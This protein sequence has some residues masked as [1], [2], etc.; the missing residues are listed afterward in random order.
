M[1][2]V[3][4]REFRA[5]AKRRSTFTLRWL[6]ALTAFVLMLWLFWLFDAYKHAAAIP[7]VFTAMSHVA[8][9]YCLLVSAARAA[10][11]ISAER[12]DGTLGLLFLTD[13]RTLEV[14]AGKLVTH[15]GVGAYGLLAIFP[16]LAVPM[17]LGG[18]TFNQFAWTILSLLNAMWFG[19][20]LG[21][22]ISVINSRQHMAIGLSLALALLCAPG[23]TALAELL[24]HFKFPPWAVDL[25]SMLS[26][27]YLVGTPIW[28]MTVKPWE[29]LASVGMV[30]AMGWVLLF[31]ALLEL[32][33][34]WRDSA[35]IHALF[36]V[37]KSRT[38]ATG[39]GRSAR[40]AAWRTRMLDLHP[41]FWL[42]GRSR[43]GSK[44]FLA[45]AVL[46]I[47]LNLGVVTKFAA[48]QFKAGPAFGSLIG[49]TMTWFGL[50]VLL[51]L[52]TAYQAGLAASHRVAED[53]QTGAL[54]LILSTPLGLRSFSRGL[55]MA[56]A[57][58]LFAPAVFATLVHLFFV[59][60]IAQLFFTEFS[61]RAGPFS[62]TSFPQYLFDCLVVP[63]AAHPVNQWLP[64]FVGRIM[65]MAWF[66]LAANWVAIGWVGRWLGLRMK[67]TG[68]A[69][70]AA[71][72]LALVP[73]WIG[74]G[75]TCYF[76]DTAGVFKGPEENTLPLG[77]WLA[78]C[79][80]FGHALMLSLWGRHRWWRYFSLVVSE[81]EAFKERGIH[82]PTL[83]RWMGYAVVTM[84]LLASANYVLQAIYTSRAKS[85]WE[86]VRQRIEG[87]GPRQTYA[88]MAPP[89][90]GDHLNF[91]Q[92]PAYSRWLES[93]GGDLTARIDES[94]AYLQASPI[95]A[96][97]SKHQKADL[98]GILGTWGSSGNKETGR[99]SAALELEEKMA[100]AG[101]LLDQINLDSKTRTHYRSLGTQNHAA[102][103]SKD[104]VAMLR[105]LR[106]GGLLSLRASVRVA[107]DRTDEAFEDVLGTLRLARIASTSIH[108][109]SSLA[110]HGILLQGLQP[111]FDGLAER[112]WK[113]SH[114]TKLQTELA[115]VNLL[116]L[117]TNAI[118][119]IAWAHADRILLDDPSIQHARI[120]SSWLGKYTK[121]LEFYRGV[122]LA[123]SR[124]DVERQR[125]EESH[126]LWNMMNSI[127]LEYATVQILAPFPWVNATS[128]SVVFAQTSI[129]QAVL[130]C[131]LEVHRQRQGAFPLSLEALTPP[132][133]GGIPKD[134]QRGLPLHYRIL[135]NG[136]F[137]IRGSGP[138]LQIEPPDRPGAGDDWVWSYEPPAIPKP[139]TAVP[140]MVR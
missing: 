117:N 96:R 29:N 83:M 65:I 76:L 9:Y 6:T 140:G 135:T 86:A 107:Q 37:L 82:G 114:L 108:Q 34:S 118:M 57:R 58:A 2:I 5:A 128:T 4:A 47:L 35:G 115:S 75:V 30:H 36:T 38:A 60:H 46:L 66:V 22:A 71:M 64:Y 123:M 31:A 98:E 25:T 49:H 110:A 120:P 124:V 73:P 53:R 91:A 32:S 130:A 54:E 78:A 3:A 20:T 100:A 80:G 122:E 45:A 13:L 56:F 87:P 121:L 132:L 136:L 127:G 52:W 67:H 27:W 129:H 17:L 97:W 94:P 59:Y 113:S 42:G 137:E 12:R 90:P 93:N 131:A 81:K 19:T 125:V 24:R 48:A 119:R 69:P 126:E 21:L 63:L 79:F 7:R 112:K 50:A 23:L 62:S 85:R 138:N 104:A 11:A 33:R 101:K 18:I 109:H 68:L 111:V 84:A 70:L 139:A 74:F 15:A 44:L 51:H 92:G 103:F 95:P 1:L 41:I 61:Q 8:F 72:V 89:D 26:P 28:R 39:G 99:V 133:P 116:R 77:L 40:Q 88:S 14:M 102:V 105:L 134:I 10:D 16:M 43:I 55:W 106:M